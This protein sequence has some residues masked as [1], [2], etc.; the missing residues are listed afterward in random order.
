MSSVDM[1]IEKLNQ[2]LAFEL[3]AINMYAHYA[4]YVNGINRIHLSPLFTTEAT[5][6]IQHAN[7]VRGAIVKLGGICVTERH[8]SE[9]VHTEDYNEMLKFALDTE[10]YASDLYHGILQ[11]VEQ[12][13]DDELFDSIEGIYFS[14]LRSIEE[15]RMLIQ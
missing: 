7:I 1:L 2:A 4:A 9:I 8:A 15:M 10:R 3:R 5:E 6:S 12:I 11:S 13:G 14:E